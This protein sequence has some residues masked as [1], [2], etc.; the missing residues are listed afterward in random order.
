MNKK[1]IINLINICMLVFGIFFM[2]LPN[3]K[4]IL[5]LDIDFFITNILNL[6]FNNLK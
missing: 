3:P 1:Q 5:Y 2:F 6:L 4:Q